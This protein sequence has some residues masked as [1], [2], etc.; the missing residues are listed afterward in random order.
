MAAENLAIDREPAVGVIGAGHAGTAWARTALRAGRQIIIAN[1]H[2][3]DSLRSAVAALGEGARAGTVDDA[4]AC[5]IVVLAVPWAAVASAVSGVDWAGRTVVDGTNPMLFPDL[6]PARWA[7]AHQARS[8]PASF[9]AHCSSRPPV[10]YRPSSSV[11]IRFFPAA[12]AHLRIRRQRAGQTGDYRSVQHR[13]LLSHRPGRPRIRRPHAAVA[14]EMTGRL[15][16]I[17][18]CRAMVSYRRRWNELCGGRQRGTT[19]RVDPWRDVEMAID[20]GDHH[21]TCREHAHIRL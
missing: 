3:P 20:G 11:T 6:T 10:T 4:V 1:S 8:S 16:D 7:A 12:D 2:G 9:P 19:G 5:A 15:G 18:A 21:R 17:R 14:A 13:R